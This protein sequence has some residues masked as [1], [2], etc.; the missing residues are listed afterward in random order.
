MEKQNRFF[1][2][3]YGSARP[4]ELDLRD[5]P[6]DL[7]ATD[8]RYFLGVLEHLDHLLRGAGITFVLTW[9]LDAFNRIMKDAV[10][11]LLGD[12][13]YQR[14][15][16]Q[17]YTR[18]VFK[19]GGVRPNPLCDTLRLPWGV[20]W[21][22][23]LR[24][25]RNRLNGI[26]RWLKHRPPRRV[27]IPMGELPLG[28]F[29][30]RAVEPPPIDERPIDAFFAGGLNANGWSVRASVSA[31]KQ[32]AAGLRAAQKALPQDRIQSLLA[33]HATGTR[34]D[35]EAYTH[36]LANTKVALAP[37]GNFDETFRLFEA[38]KLGCVIVSGP[39]PKRWYYRDSPVVSIPKWSTLREVL[40]DLL[41]DPPR[42]RELSL[43]T[44]QWWDQ[45]LSEV[46]VASYIAERLRSRATGRT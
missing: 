42:L 35:P 28:Y 2:W 23:A 46:A 45:Q 5:L 41:G 7:P 18:A 24:E 8:V 29:Q 31:R 25:V 15:S 19:T 14:P 40:R 10:I 39:L 4:M 43:R 30:L 3:P 9:H 17:H 34:L 44:R 21:R 20:A 26:H 11:L 38:A 6:A 33:A 32:M 16:Y 13:Q 36:A 37:R 12:E 1:W 22:A 27:V